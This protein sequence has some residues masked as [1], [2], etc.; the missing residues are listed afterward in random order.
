MNLH[1]VQLP[2]LCMESCGPMMDGTYMYVV[3]H[4]YTNKTEDLINERKID[5]AHVSK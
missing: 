2:L 4:I 5:F 1:L 3:Y